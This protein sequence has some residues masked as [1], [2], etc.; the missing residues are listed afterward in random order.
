MTVSQKIVPIVADDG[1]ANQ[2][3]L[4]VI[5]LLSI[6]ARSSKQ[7]ITFAIARLDI[8]E[9]GDVRSRSRLQRTL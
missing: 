7:V 1:H 4:I 6:Y 2:W 9:G 5:A 3:S 8:I